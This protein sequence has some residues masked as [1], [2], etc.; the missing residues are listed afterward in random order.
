MP[1]I[2][3]YTQVHNAGE[4]LEPCISSVLAQTFSD[5][6]YIIVDNASTDGSRELL[7]HFAAV[8]S[9]I[10]LIKNSE[11]Q[12]RI[13][14]GILKEYA[15]GD[16]YA[17]LDH[18]DWLEPK[19]FE[20]L[21][22]FA[23]ENNLDIGCAGTCMH[24]M[25]T[26]GVGYRST[27]RPF[28]LPRTKFAEGY[29]YYHTFLRTN[30]GKVIR[31]RLL[32]DMDGS[33][34]PPL[35][36]GGDT[37]QLFHILRKAER[38]GVDSAVLHH[39]RIHPESQSYQYSPKR[40]DADVCLY[41]DAVDFLAGFGSVSC[42][43]LLFIRRVYANALVDTSGVIEKSSLEPEGKLREYR[44]ILEHP[45]TRS[46]Y[47]Q[48]H[49]EIRNSGRIL[50]NRV[51]RAG[52]QLENGNAELAVIIRN[53]AP[54]C[55][56][57]MTEEDIAFLAR[58]PRM[59]EALWNDDRT[60]LADML[61]VLVKERVYDTRPDLCKILHDILPED[62]LLHMVK[63]IHF[64]KRHSE[65]CRQILWGKRAEALDEMTGRLLYG[66]KRHMEELYLQ[67]YL[68]LAA[69]EGQETAFVFGK[70]RLAE[71]NLRA[72]RLDDCRELLDELEEMGVG[73]HGEVIGLREKLKA[74]EVR[75]KC[76]KKYL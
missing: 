48:P 5:F 11:N 6:E 37:L 47:A 28:V 12:M 10:R 68:S 43:N 51:V 62:S 27:P 19:F 14:V 69:L 52:R 49:E 15:K 40:F 66:R 59:S 4:Y 29:P 22:A 56:S 13:R 75:Q 33:K 7:E 50:L 61:L 54:N 55:C 8:D 36:Y 32:F 34:I 9:R 24:D 74:K 44:R 76:G 73:E 65:L 45:I 42:E 26:G 64:L 23:E 67:L 21:L 16:F 20:R 30:W 35:S 58:E 70:I 71:W 41:E 18:D 72:G 25:T 17:V 2:T 38:I 31:T 57:G 63:D 39:Y 3:L 53:M 1:K 46:A 60:A